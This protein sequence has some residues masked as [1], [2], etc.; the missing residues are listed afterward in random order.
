MNIKDM[1]TKSHPMQASR[2]PRV[3]ATRQRLTLRIYPWVF[4]FSAFVLFAGPVWAASSFQTQVPVFDRKPTLNGTIDASWKGA[5]ALSVNFDFTY[6]RA[7]EPTTVYVAQDATG[8][9]V[10]FDVTQ[11]HSIV[12]EQ[13]T[14]GS[15]VLQDDN[16]T[17]FLYPQ[18]VRGFAYTFTANANGTRYQTSSENTAYSPDWVAAAR[19]TGNG[20]TVTMHIPYNIVRSTGSGVWRAQFTR[21]ILSLNATQVWEHEA[22]QSRAA[23]PTLAGTMMG[24][25]DAKKQSAVRSRARLQLYALGELTTKNYGGSTS[26]MGLDVAVPVTSTSSLVA[27][28]HP[29]YSNVEVDQQT[30]APNAFQRRYNEVRPFFT[31]V[32]SN[33]NSLFSCN[34]CPTTLYTPAIPNFSQGYAYEGTQGPFAFAAFN[35]PGTNRDDN[36]QVLT[37]TEQSRRGLAAISLQ[38]V[39]TTSTNLS[40]DATTISAGYLNRYTHYYGYVNAGVDRGTNVTEPGFGDYFEYGVGYGG[41]LT[42]IGI[43]FQ[44]IGPQFR[45]ADGFVTQAGIAGYNIG[46]SH[47]IQFSSTASLQDIVVSA[48]NLNF[49][50][51]S[52][53]R[54]QIQQNGEVDFD[55]AH[56]ISLHLYSGY[57]AYQTVSGQFLPFNANGFNLS[58]KGRT[59]T[60][61]SVSYSGGSYNN[62]KLTSWSYVATSPLIRRVNLGLEVD[63]NRYVPHVTAEPTAQQWLERASVDWQFSRNASVDFGARRIIGRNLP[64]AFQMPD[65]PTAQLPLGTINGFA[66]FDYVNAANLSFA[67][68]FL[69]ARNEFYIVY[70]DPNSLVTT[71]AI[72]V[73]LIRYVGAGKGT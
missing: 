5:V 26:R 4:A 12:A 6:Q 64:N 1:T 61:S 62:G 66:P 58:Y 56:L 71:P 57:A 69:T 23:D 28:L 27:T 43:D 47:T 18:G 25:G 2:E 37:Y 14:N 13:H 55:F 30:I 29:D 19:R 39:N 65:L 20:Y 15:G 45:P 53:H 51:P 36:A 34:N 72:F 42:N 9:D 50:D 54:A 3:V 68:H 32:G 31:Q 73:K 48:N 35:A 67:L 11:R 33:F 59:T 63:E 7:G 22:G 60:P 10:A 46:G 52:A 8:L 17:I 16:V 40:D 49:H 41:K 44:K 24:I 38:R 21:T 70:G